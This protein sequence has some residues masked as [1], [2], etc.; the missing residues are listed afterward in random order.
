MVMPALIEGGEVTSNEGEYYAIMRALIAAKELGLKVLEVQSDSQLIVN[1]LND[2]YEARD[3]R[4]EGLRRLV[5]EFAQDFDKVTYHWIPREQ[6]PAGKV[7][8]KLEKKQ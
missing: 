5:R 3:R 1:Q 7:L 2:K 4:M 6:N 8:E